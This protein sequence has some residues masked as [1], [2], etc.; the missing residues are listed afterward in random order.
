[1]GDKHLKSLGQCTSPCSV[2]LMRGPRQAEASVT[3][4]ICTHRPDSLVFF[5]LADST[6]RDPESFWYY[7]DSSGDIIWMFT[8]Q[9]VICIVPPTFTPHS[10]AWLLLVAVLAHDPAVSVPRVSFSWDRATLENGDICAEKVIS[11]AS[12]AAGLPLEIPLIL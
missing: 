9:F 8:H 10:S 7:A 5:L 4:S 11:G 2:F 1:M 3:G 6:L 12:K